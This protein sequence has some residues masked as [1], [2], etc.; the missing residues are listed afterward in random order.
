MTSN[1]TKL[2]SWYIAKSVAM[3][4]DTIMV[5]GLLYFG[6]TYGF[7]WWIILLLVLTVLGFSR[8]RNIDGEYT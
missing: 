1:T 5:L 7:S 8:F 3:I 2:N 4:T 6:Y